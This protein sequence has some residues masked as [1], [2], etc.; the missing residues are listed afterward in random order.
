[1]KMKKHLI[2]SMLLLGFAGMLE[3]ENVQRTLPDVV[4]G[5]RDEVISLNGEWQFQYAPGEKWERVTVPGEL[6]M[7][8]YGIEHD[9]PVL[10]KKTVLVP[11][12]YR[13]KQVILRF[14]GV[15]S[16]ARLWVNG[17][18]AAEHAGGFTRWETDITSLIRIGKKNEIR[19]E[20]TDRLNDISYASG[21]AH[22]PIGGILRGVSLYA[23]PE[24][25]MRDFFVETLLD[26]A[27]QDADL[28]IV[29]SMS[30]SAKVSFTLKEKKSGR[31][32]LESGVL[33]CQQGDNEH[34]FRISRPE[35]WDA[36]HPN[37]YV[38]QVNVQSADGGYSFEREI[39]FRKIEVK[40]D[41]ML[42]NGKQVPI[43]TTAQVVNTRTYLPIR[44]VLEAF[45][46]LVT[47]NEAD[48]TV[49][50]STDSSLLRV[51]F[52][53][54]GQGDS[55]LIDC[56]ETEVLIDGGDNRAGQDVVGYL[57]AYVDGPLDYLI[58]THP[59]ADHVGGL[60]AVL[61]AF[62]V[63]EVIDSGKS[64]DTAS[65]RDYWAAVQAN[66]CTVS[67]DADRIIVLDNGRIN[68][69]GTHEELLA[70]NEIYRE[71]YESQ[72]K[73]GDD[74]AAPAV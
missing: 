32:C 40:G 2:L 21:Y 52:L 7:Q 31:V 26:D 63:G 50:V 38:L 17:K 62:K 39:G 46:A 49:V 65:Y 8:G 67:Q 23:L 30:A 13:G 64:A 55:I 72:V 6:A 18:Q 45:G 74:H 16:Y 9:K 34:R 36:E 57:Q 25:N 20:V 28:R 35:L 22:H 4:E 73:G 68:A 54:V 70:S 61:K 59:D 71:V 66:G 58:A 41:R 14:D 5:V 37:L 44:P 12:D 11:A 47:W 43:D 3:A 56:G 60:D 53:D 29:Y 1:M 42:V 48:K 33:A 27:Y 51:H 24:S 10:Y 69:V 15:Y 19:L